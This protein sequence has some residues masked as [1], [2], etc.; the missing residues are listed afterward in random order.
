MSWEK[1]DLSQLKLVS[2]FV[3]KSLY[4]FYLTNR[5]YVSLGLFN[6]RSQMTSKSGKNINL[7][8]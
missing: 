7:A 5:F 8:H 1:W 4:D 2:S 3:N 6:N